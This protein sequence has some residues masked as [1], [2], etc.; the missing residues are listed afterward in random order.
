MIDPDAG[1]W[2]CQSCGNWNW[3][4]RDACNKCGVYKPQ[5]LAPPP[6]LPPRP[7]GAPGS[8]F[9]PEKRRG[10]AGGFKEFDAEEA[11]RRKRRAEEERTE[12]QEMKKQKKKC[13]YCHRAACIC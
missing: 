10:E 3:A 12:R 4:R 11:A 6:R 7:P 13:A 1:D 8:S 2:P 9:V 5:S